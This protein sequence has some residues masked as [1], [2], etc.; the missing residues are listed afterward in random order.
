MLKTIWFW[1][2]NSRVFTLP[3]SIFSWLVVFTFGLTSNGNVLCGVL[4]LIGI[5]CCQLAT[6]LFDDY[7]DYQKLMKMGTLE[8]QTKSKCAY[9]TNGEATLMMF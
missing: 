2:E 7:L 8:H 5:C 3:M 9:I 4:A 6:N 1:L